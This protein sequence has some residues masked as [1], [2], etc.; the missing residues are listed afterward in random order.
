MVDRPADRP[1]PRRLRGRSGCQIAHRCATFDVPAFSFARFAMK[2]SLPAR[3]VSKPSIAR[4]P[5]ACAHRPPAAPPVGAPPPPA[6]L[7]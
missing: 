6:A 5:R 3:A 2:P 1:S 4:L 7:G